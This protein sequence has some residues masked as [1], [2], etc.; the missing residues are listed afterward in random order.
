M[1]QLTQDVYYAR[2]QQYVFDNINSIRTQDVKD[3]IMHLVNHMTKENSQD[4]YGQIVNLFGDTFRGYRHDFNTSCLKTSG[5][6]ILVS[7]CVALVGGLADHACVKYNW[8][9]L[10]RSWI[11]TMAGAGGVGVLIG[12]CMLLAIGH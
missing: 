3:Q 2:A 11:Q 5:M 7:A 8:I 12:F 9:P 10:Y 1:E 6:V 4:V